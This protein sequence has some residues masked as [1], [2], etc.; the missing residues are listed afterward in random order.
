MLE[1]QFHLYNQEKDYMIFSKSSLNSTRQSSFYYIWH[2][3]LLL[4]Y[5]PITYTYSEALYLSKSLTLLKNNIRSLSY[6]IY[7]MIYII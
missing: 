5:E 2:N 6:V 3:I 1:H 4:Y 7:P